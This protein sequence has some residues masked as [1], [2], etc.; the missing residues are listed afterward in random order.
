MGGCGGKIAK[1]GR[2]WYYENSEIKLTVYEK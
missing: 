1:M 2:D